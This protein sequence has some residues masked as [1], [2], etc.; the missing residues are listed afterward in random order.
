[1]VGVPLVTKREGWRRVARDNNAKVN[2]WE[3]GR[4]KRVRD[5]ERQRRAEVGTPCGCVRTFNERRQ[6][7]RRRVMER[8]RRMEE[9]H[10]GRLPVA[11]R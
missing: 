7:T 9:Y 11:G 3:R 6:N 2:K 4:R 8:R 10:R 5:K 1:M